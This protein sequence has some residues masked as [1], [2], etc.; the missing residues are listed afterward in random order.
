MLVVRVSVLGD[1]VLSRAISRFGEGVGDFRP[2][3]RQIRDDFYRIEAEQFESEGARG[4]AGPWPALSPRY[5]TWKAKNVPGIPIMQLTGWMAGQ[6]A[7]GR[8][9]TEEMEPMTLRLA[10][11]LDYPVYHQRGSAKTGLPRRKVVDL[12]EEDKE[13]WMRMLHE[14]VWEKAKEARLA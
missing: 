2:A 7:S 13:G 10:P 4:P 6:M 11:T 14:Y 8:G 3:W 12:T 9:M 5:G 1:M